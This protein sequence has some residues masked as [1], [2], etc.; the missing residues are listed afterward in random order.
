MKA[1]KTKIKLCII[2]I[3][4]IFIS[5]FGLWSFAHM[6]FNPN[7][8]ELPARVFYCCFSTLTAILACVGIMSYNE[9]KNYF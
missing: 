4:V 2:V 7:N 6:S 3:C 8:W 5:Y 9:H 1:M